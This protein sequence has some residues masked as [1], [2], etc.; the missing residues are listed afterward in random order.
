MQ[1]VAANSSDKSQ[2]NNATMHITKISQCKR[3]RLQHTLGRDNRLKLSKEGRMLGKIF[4]GRNW[5][6]MT[7]NIMCNQIH[8]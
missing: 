8:N 7:S 2:Q 1:I 6:T 3:A 5:T 4:V